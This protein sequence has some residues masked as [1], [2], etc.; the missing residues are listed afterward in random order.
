M[1]PAE[2]IS[3]TKKVSNFLRR[4]AATTTGKDASRKPP[5][6]GRVE[7]IGDDITSTV[8][9]SVTMP[10]EAVR[11]GRHMRN[12][13]RRQH[14]DFDVTSQVPQRPQI[15]AAD[16]RAN[17]ILR[18]YSKNMAEWEI[19]ERGDGYRPPRARPSSS[20]DEDSL[21][22]AESTVSMESDVDVAPR[23]MPPPPPPPR[24]TT[25]RGV[26]PQPPLS[27]S[28]TGHRG[29]PP[30]LPPPPR[31]TTSRPGAAPQPAPNLPPP[32]PLS[33]PYPIRPRVSIR[34]QP[35]D[36][37]PNSPPL[38]QVPVAISSARRVI[39]GR[40]QVNRNLGSF[41][42]S[43]PQETF[44]PFAGREVAFSPPTWSQNTPP[45]PPLTHSY[46][47]HPVF[48]PQQRYQ[49]QQS[50][51]SGRRYP[52]PQALPPQFFSPTQAPPA[53][54]YRPLQLSREPAS[55]EQQDIGV[56]RPYPPPPPPA[57]E[58]RVCHSVFHPATV[59]PGTNILIQPEDQRIMRQRLRESRSERERDMAPNPWFN[60]V[61][62][63][64][65]S[66]SDVESGDDYPHEMPVIDNSI[67]DDGIDEYDPDAVTLNEYGQIEEA[68]DE[69][70]EED[71]DNASEATG[72]RSVHDS[73][74]DDGDDG[75]GPATSGNGPSSGNGHSSASG[76]SSGKGYSSGNGPSSRHYH[77][78][79]N[80]YYSGTVHS[81]GNGYPS[82]QDDYC[83]NIASGNSISGHDVSVHDA[84]THDA[85]HPHPGNDNSI[86]RGSSSSVYSNEDVSSI[87]NYHSYLARTVDKTETSSGNNTKTDEGDNGSPP[88]DASANGTAPG[89]GPSEHHA[90][91]NGAAQPSVFND[92]SGSRKS[93]P[94]GYSDDDKCSIEDY[95]E[96]L[97]RT[98]DYTGNRSGRHTENDDV[99]GPANTGNGPSENDASGH[100]SSGHTA[101]GHGASAIVAFEPSVG[102]DDSNSRVS[103]PTGYTDEDESSVEDYHQYLSATAT[104]TG[105][106]AGNKTDNKEGAG[107]AASGSDIS[108]GN[109]VSGH[110]VSGHGSAEPYA[111]NNDSGSR[112]SSPTGYSDEDESSIEDYHE[113]LTR[114]AI[115][116]PLQ[117]QLTPSPCSPAI[118]ANIQDLPERVEHTECSGYADASHDE[119]NTAQNSPSTRHANDPQSRAEAKSPKASG[120]VKSFSHSSTG[121]TTALGALFR[122]RTPMLDDKRNVASISIFEQAILYSR[123]EFVL[124]TTTN[125]FLMR[126]RAYLKLD[127][128]RK[129]V[130]TWEAGSWSFWEGNRVRHPR[131]VEFMYPLN[132]QVALVEAHTDIFV[133]KA[134]F[135]YQ[136][137]PVSQ[138]LAEEIIAGW[139]HM[140]AS[141]PTRTLQMPDCFV[142]QHIKTV[143]AVLVLLGRNAED[144]TASTLWH[145]SE[146][147]I[148]EFLRHGPH[149]QQ[150]GPEYVFDEQDEYQQEAEYDQQ[151]WDYQQAGYDEQAQQDIDSGHWEYNRTETSTSETGSYYDESIADDYLE[152]SH[153]D[154]VYPD[155]DLGFIGDGKE[156]AL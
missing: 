132:L 18:Q 62:Y 51:G 45:V 85:G 111:D 70:E 123:L 115:T 63:H 3:L 151:V 41:A 15:S 103:S 146:T 25:G 68:E 49:Q 4:R 75:A 141:L 136:G 119:A 74:S 93:S 90:S 81:T 83:G 22:S 9:R 131:V 20:E 153:S 92:T 12:S 121:I 113:Y 34:Q 86:F 98:V 120:L 47:Q 144:P 1:P 72:N 40:E 24:R 80:G 43:P 65:D 67:D 55:I 44:G 122:R 147:R 130:E 112:K 48:H 5:R 54:S 124:T 110:G 116:E 148:M 104:H 118:A 155:A 107:L 60:P 14:I 102:V 106:R 76:P 77:Y 137:C 10:E 11:Q 57:P 2:K 8:P 56:A 7:T 61:D 150:F 142:I 154:G 50:M 84:S 37:F 149:Q 140:V 58:P 105:N 64:Y 28:T 128:V 138:R 32:L 6:E 152:D 39:V 94:T 133:E 59:V 13:T 100:V 26:V 91:G 125:N 126:H 69:E 97:E 89:N 134:C 36:L 35:P 21:F 52:P 143:N 101:S 78:S 95:H 139:K 135:E 53:T 17:R 23:R 87:E 16:A 19:R 88:D 38:Y 156:L 66:S 27:R 42:R 127:A 71:I 129:I 108:P 31:N 99:A 109:D 29:A 79:D 73:K 145:Q 46:R 117:S 114:T 96:Y 30:P 82:G 33:G